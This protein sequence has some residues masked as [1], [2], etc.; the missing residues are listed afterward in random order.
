MRPDLRDPR[1]TQYVLNEI[2]AEDKATVEKWLR[3]D[4]HVRRAVEEIRALSEVL[5]EELHG[6]FTPVEKAISPAPTWGERLA[7]WKKAIYIAVPI[8]AVA[9]LIFVNIPR[10]K[11]S[12]VAIKEAAKTPVSTPSE[13]FYQKEQEPRETIPAAPTR[14]DS[15]DMATGAS[16][17]A[18]PRKALAQRLRGKQMA[19]GLLGQTGGSGFVPGEGS[20]EMSR[21]AYSH[22]ADN[23]FQKVA[24]HPLSTFSVDVDTASY[25]NVRRFLDGHQLPPKDA[26][27]IEEMVNY[28]DYGYAP[29]SGDVPFAVHTELASAPW[30]P[31]HKLL[32]IG[33]KGKPIDWKSR[34]NSNL[35]F[36]LDVSGSMMDADKLPLVQQSLKLL[37]DQLGKR[38]RVAI[39]VYAGASGLVL[40]STPLN[41]KDEILAAIDRLQAGGSTNGGAGIQLAYRVAQENF[42]KGGINRVILATDGDFNVGTTSEGELVRL[43]QDKAKSGVFL[44]VLGFGTGNYQDANMEKLADKGNGNYAYIDGLGEAKKVLVE[45][46][47]GTMITIAKDVKIQIE[48]NPAKVAGY[49]LIGYENRL[50]AKEDFNDDKKDAGEIGAGHTVTALYEIVPAGAVLPGSVDELKYQKVEKKNTAAS[51]SASGEWLT[52][53]LRYKK[54]EGDISSKIEHPVGGEAK[55]FASASP[56]FKFASAVAGFGML[57]RDSEFKGN[58]TF[59][60]VREM[61]IEGK[62]EDAEGYRSELIRLIERAKTLQPAK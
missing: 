10:E 37:V 39:V 59:D 44:T 21:E 5:G 17:A 18:E 58:A 33:L 20:F 36:L 24:D 14:S 41:K 40:P 52:V 23:G 49:R 11:L 22:I 30:K 60:G 1:L 7:L 46:A 43:I 25:A 16:A 42:I 35:V 29:P 54:P 57:L 2:S 31:E 8:A 34:K 15:G 50:L 6:E 56:D 62:G 38:D 26:V 28:F 9:T 55:E 45:Q 3:E 19:M 61:A 47:G 48:F 32:R 53:K 13:V 12:E 4:P 27:R 51:P